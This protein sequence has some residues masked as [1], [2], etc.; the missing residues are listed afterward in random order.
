MSGGASSTVTDRVS[1]SVEG[2]EAPEEPGSRGQRRRKRRYHHH[3]HRN[4]QKRTGKGY[5]FAFV[6]LLALAI[7][8]WILYTLLPST[9]KHRN[10]D[11]ESHLVPHVRLSLLSLTG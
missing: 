6:T 10:T 2:N 8:F 11:E 4:L 3:H 5:E 7:L 9:E 1:G